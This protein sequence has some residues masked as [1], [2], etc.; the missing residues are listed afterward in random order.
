MY[1]EEPYAQSFLRSEE[2]PPIMSSNDYQSRTHERGP[3]PFGVLHSFSLPL[4]P[5]PPLSSS[6][7]QN[8]GQFLQEAPRTRFANFKR[9]VLGEGK[10][11]ISFYISVGH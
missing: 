2:S 1:T 10:S 8:Q 4:P 9:D 7:L 3:P 6:H 11:S 5:A